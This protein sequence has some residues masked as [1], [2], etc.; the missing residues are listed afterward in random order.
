[1]MLADRLKKSVEEIL[2]MTTLERDLWAGFILY[3]HN[4]SKKQ[5]RIQQP[6]PVRRKR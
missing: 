5:S 3:E 4:E 6:R 1:M 2:Q